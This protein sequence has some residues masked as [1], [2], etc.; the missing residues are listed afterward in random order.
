MG[1]LNVTPDS[2]SDGGAYSSADDALRRVDEFV[3]AGVDILDVG[4]ES[5]RPGSEP[6]SDDQQI[7]RL[8]DVVRGARRAHPNLPISID[9]RSAA[10]ARHAIELGADIINDVTAL[11]DDPDLA[12]VAAESESPVIVMH[13][14]GQPKTMQRDPE[15]IAYADVV[16]EIVAFLRERIAAAREAGVKKERIAIDPGIGFGKTTEHNLQI[17]R[18]LGDLVALGHPVVVGASRK[19]FLGELTGQSDPRKRLAGSLACAVVAASSG[20]HVIRAHDVGPTK[21][22]VRIAT[23]IRTA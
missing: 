20:V 10:V 9:T 21:N 19:R 17:L 4:A 15:R 2:F 23:A 22:A 11:R 3:A 14:R 18:R 6:V 5:T 16:E 12:N 7:R 13:M 1:V 8:S